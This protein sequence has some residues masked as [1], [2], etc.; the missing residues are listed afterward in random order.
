MAVDKYPEPKIQLQL[1]R[2]SDA[3]RIRD[4]AGKYYPPMTL[5]KWRE[6][7]RIKM[8]RGEELFF[9]SKE[10]RDIGG[11]NVAAPFGS[12]T[13]KAIRIWTNSSLEEGELEEILR[14]LVGDDED[15]YRLDV[16]FS[17]TELGMRRGNGRLYE[18]DWPVKRMT[19][20]VPQLSLKKVAFMPWAFGYLALVTTPDCQKIESIQFLRKGKEGLTNLVKQTAYYRG[21]LGFEGVIPGQEDPFKDQECPVLEKARQELTLYLSGHH[22]PDIPFEFPRGTPFQERVWQEALKIP[23]GVVRTYADIVEAIEP[24]K[25]KSGQMARAVGRALGANP[26]PILI[27]CHRVIGS[28]RTLTG[29]GGGVDIKDHLL[30]LEMWDSRPSG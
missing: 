8:S 12:K 3:K 11:A 25:N 5:A 19:Y 30:Q 16:M 6:E 24:D 22:V 9:I 21:L 13:W 18:V 1:F 10:G 17:D 15:L 4:L 2:M 28:N 23:Y 26:L 27:P 20:Y 14:Q 7:A 29:F